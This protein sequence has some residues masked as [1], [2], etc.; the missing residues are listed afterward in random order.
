MQLLIMYNENNDERKIVW[1]TIPRPSML[2]KVKFT[3]YQ[4]LFLLKLIS[5]VTIH[6]QTGFVNKINAGNSCQ[7]S[8]ESR[9]PVF[10]YCERCKPHS[11]AHVAF[12]SREQQPCL[13]KACSLIG[14]LHSNLRFGFQRRLTSCPT[15]DASTLLAQSQHSRLATK[16]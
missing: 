16:C 9:A 6:K 5:F 13:T 10:F 12:L 8:A 2:H 14:A 11:T 15:F 4:S 7:H 3:L 1:S